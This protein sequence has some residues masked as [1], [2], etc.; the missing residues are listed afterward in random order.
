MQHCFS[1][2]FDEIFPPFVLNTET[3]EPLE[4]D[5]RQRLGEDICQIKISWGIPHA[6][7]ALHHGL[8][9]KLQKLK[10]TSMCLLLPA[11]LHSFS[12]IKIA[13][14]LSA[15]IRVDSSRLCPSCTPSGKTPALE[16]P[17]QLYQAF[18]SF[19]AAT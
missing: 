3:P 4:G 10:R 6:H 14:F 8:C 18:S 16:L 2:F 19:D 9:H 11:E 13:A 12:A 15:Q 5:S 17:E 7:R 1:T